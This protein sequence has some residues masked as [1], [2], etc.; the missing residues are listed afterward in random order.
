MRIVEA[1]PTT[2]TSERLYILDILRFAAALG[3]TIFHFGFHQWAMERNSPVHFPELAPWAVYGGLAV[4]LFFII[5]GFVIAVS[6]QGKTAGQFAFGRFIRLYPTFWI[7][8]LLTALTLY[9]WGAEEHQFTLHGFLANLTMIPHLLHQPYL[10]E[11]YWTLQVEIR[12]YVLMLLLLML[13]KGSWLMPFAVVWLGLSAVDWVYGIPVLHV[14]LT[15]DNA[16]FFVAGIVYSQMFRSGAKWHHWAV[17]ATALVVGTMRVIRD[18]EL[19]VAGSG[20][21]VSPAVIS[22]A[23]A[24]IF[25]IFAGIALGK[26]YLKRSHK[27][28][29][30]LGGMTY[31]LYLLHNNIGLVIF[32]RVNDAMNRWLLFA[33]MLAGLMV[34]AFAIWRWI[35]TPILR[36]FRPRKTSGLPAA[37]EELFENAPI[38]AS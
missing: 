8:L 15:L 23:L 26:I 36:K 4:P 27:W 30:A 12:F 11:P 9:S 31:P 33:L 18:M 2:Q 28:V 19:D 20:W 6:M 35:E 24:V 13:R 22:T 25:I 1:A 5:S 17:L 7:C 21:S 14:Q 32:N 37:R 3:V 38:S 10:D 16:P 29:V 34:M